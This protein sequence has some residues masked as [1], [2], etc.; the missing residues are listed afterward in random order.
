MKCPKCERDGR[1]QVLE[2]R[3]ADGKVWRRRLCKL[4]HIVYVSCETAEPGMK[5][6]PETQ[7][8][9]RKLKSLEELRNQPDWR[10]S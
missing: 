7:S 4:C 2:S 6:P 8:K 10:K 9:N 3:P 5:M 1:S